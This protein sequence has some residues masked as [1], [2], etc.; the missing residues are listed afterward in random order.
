MVPNFMQRWFSRAVE[1][2][3]G[4]F[5]ALRSS[6]YFIATT[7]EW[8]GDKI[9]KAQYSKETFQTILQHSATMARQ[10]DTMELISRR[11]SNFVIYITRVQPEHIEAYWRFA[12]K[13]SAGFELRNFEDFKIKFSEDELFTP[14]PDLTITVDGDD[15]IK[16]IAEQIQGTV[17]LDITLRNTLDISEFKLGKTKRLHCLTRLNSVAQRTGNPEHASTVRLT[18]SDPNEALIFKMRMS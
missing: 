14:N 9:K 8:G 5:G 11:E 10:L 18:F 6:H 15:L 4:H 3:A 17:R 12:S 7:A 2:T 16:N 1:L 13:S